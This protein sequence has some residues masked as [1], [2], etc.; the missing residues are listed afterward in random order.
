M[1]NWELVS[2]INIFW[3]FVE[4]QQG[5]LIINDI[6]P[7]PPRPFIRYSQY[8]PSLQSMIKDLIHLYEEKGE[9]TMCESYLQIDE[10][11]TIRH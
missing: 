9:K 8:F 10:V 2:V 4:N 5:G 6:Y 3:I 7:G 1:N 11:L